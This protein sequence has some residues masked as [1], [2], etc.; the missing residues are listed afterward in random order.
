M[1]THLTILAILYVITSAGEL[2]AA[3]AIFGVAA[4]AGF[5]VADL[6]EVWLITGVGTLAGIFLLILALPGLILAAGLLLRRRWARVW[7][8]ILG[9]L[10]LLNFPIGTVLGFYTIWALT[11]PEARR[12]LGIDTAAA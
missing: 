5:F 12:L 7:G 1:G 2:L 4:G 8:L 11:R 3:L 10:N 9:V 6:P